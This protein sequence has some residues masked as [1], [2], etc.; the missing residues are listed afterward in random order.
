ME[1]KNKPD[2]KNKFSF[3]KSN[4]KDILLISI[5][6]IAL[7][8]VVIYNLYANGVFVNTSKFFNDCKLAFCSTFDSLFKKQNITE[9]NDNYANSQNN[10]N[11]QNYVE[12]KMPNLVGKSNIE[13]TYYYYFNECMI[14]ELKKADLSG[15][16]F[17]EKL[18]QEIDDNTITINNTIKYHDPD[19]HALRIVSQ[20]PA[21][22]EIIRISYNND[23]TI[24][25]SP[26]IEVFEEDYGEKSY[27]EKVHEINLNKNRKTPSVPKK[28]YKPE[29]DSTVMTYISSYVLT[30]KY[31]YKSHELYK[32]LNSGNNLV[33]V[34]M[35]DPSTEGSAYSF[36]KFY[37]LGEFSPNG[38]IIK[39]SDICQGYESVYYEYIG[40]WGY[41]EGDQLY[42][43][44]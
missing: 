1:E 24:S 18:I 20:N 14:E 41:A 2:N 9:N 8:L 15:T 22:G 16:K 27:D 39:W 38:N 19:T 23:N 31:K 10:D 43:D 44:Y 3:V 17:N 13:L 5:I 34:E 21:A 4:I 28:V 36:V 42:L 33:L 30:T 35:T 12:I 29:N 25:I 40:T 6:M 11:L 26:D 32:K 7:L 37:V